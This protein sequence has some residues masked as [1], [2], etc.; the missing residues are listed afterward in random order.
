MS[1]LEPRVTS[2][3]HRS[4]RH[5]GSLYFLIR[6]TFVCATLFRRIKLN[7]LYPRRPPKE[8]CTIKSAIR[9][10]NRYRDLKSRYQ[11]LHNGTNFQYT[12]AA[13]VRT[14]LCTYLCTF[15]L[16][17]S[18][19][20]RTKFSTRTGTYQQVCFIVSVR[21]YL[22]LQHTKL[23]LNLVLSIVG[24]STAVALPSSDTGTGI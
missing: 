6:H 21:P 15:M 18:T 8:S 22:Q 24:R 5:F 3:A 14:S 11:I 7:Q 19:Y 9:R 20:S 23:V 4:M 10:D 12:C 17:S 16:Y 13:P 1:V 2:N